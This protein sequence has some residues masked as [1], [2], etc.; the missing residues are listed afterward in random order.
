MASEE[1]PLQ[2]DIDLITLLREW[3]MLKE[4]ID[5]ISQCGIRKVESL[6]KMHSCDISTIFPER[7][8]LEQKIEF[9]YHLQKWKLQNNVSMA[10]I[11]RN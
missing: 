11:I 7:C 6:K 3:G 1:V 8:D 4:T 9:R 5:L 2:M 10:A